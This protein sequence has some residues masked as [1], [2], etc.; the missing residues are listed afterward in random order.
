M[1]IKPIADRPSFPFGLLVAAMIAAPFLSSV[2]VVVSSNT[3]ALFWISPVV[4]GVYW[5]VLL[6]GMHWRFRVLGMRWRSLT[7]TDRFTTVVGKGVGLSAGLI[8]VHF[9]LSAVMVS[10]SM[11]LMGQELTQSLLERE[12]MSILRLMDPERTP[13]E[14]A[15]FVLMAVVAAPVVEELFFRGYVFPVFKSVVGRHAAWMSAVLFAVVHF[16]WLN[17]IP[18][19]ALGWLLALVYDRTGDIRVVAIAHGLVNGFVT[20][21]AFL[22]R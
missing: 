9:A 7:S 10:L 5:A 4:Q 11:R 17:F 19:L 3:D 14:I 18:V 21:V 1:N 12:R 8:A 16:Y 13:V 22:A 6:V 2:L 15:I 20:L